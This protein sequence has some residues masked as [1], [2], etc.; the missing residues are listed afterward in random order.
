MEH[1]SNENI[2]AALKLLEETAKHK[3][4]ELKMAMSDKYTNLKDLIL[5]SEASLMRSLTNAKDR[6]V[7]VATDAKEASVEKARQIACDV[8]QNVHR[9]PWPY[10]AGSALVGLLLGCMLSRSHK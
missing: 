8:D 5:E 2:A 7:E 10:I 4:D 9:N 6:A 1:T 3:K